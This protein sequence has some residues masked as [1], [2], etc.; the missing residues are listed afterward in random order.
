M[1]LRVAIEESGAQI[2]Y[3]GL[4]IVMADPTQLDQRIDV[5]LYTSEQASQSTGIAGAWFISGGVSDGGDCGRISAGFVLWVTVHQ[6]AEAEG[7][8]ASAG[9]NRPAA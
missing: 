6:T 5:L 8:G 7:H 9:S 1:N 2:S 3:E 4:P